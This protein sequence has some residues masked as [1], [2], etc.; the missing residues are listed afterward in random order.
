MNSCRTYSEY[1][2]VG[3]SHAD[4]TAEN[5][6]SFYYQRK[7]V[8]VLCLV[9]SQLP[10]SY[11][12]PPPAPHTHTQHG[13]YLCAVKDILYTPDR[14]IITHAPSDHTIIIT[15]FCFFFVFSGLF[16]FF[17]NLFFSSGAPR[18]VS[19]SQPGGN[20]SKWGRGEHDRCA[21]TC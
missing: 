4:C 10:L 2:L 15:A 21:S 16:L 14:T 1:V 13:K 12:P 3:T 19:R 20:G 11:I 5:L 9:Q 7:T 17:P 8:T 6:F 18:S